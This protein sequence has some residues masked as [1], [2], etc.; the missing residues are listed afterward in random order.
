M[1]AVASTALILGYGIGLVLRRLSRAY[2]NVRSA[3]PPLA[4]GGS[5]RCRLCGADLAGSEPVRSCSYCDTES[6]VTGV[7]LDRV[8]R[9]ARQGLEEARRQLEQSTD[10]SLSVLERSASSLETLV[11][12]QVFW[13]Q[14]PLVVALDGYFGP[15]RL[16]LACAAIVVANL[17]AGGIGLRWLRSLSE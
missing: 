13:L 5:A 10:A 11:L 14:I 15:L 16:T 8:E 12:L 7:T 17:V 9:G 6:I 4:A 1:A 3:L 2:S